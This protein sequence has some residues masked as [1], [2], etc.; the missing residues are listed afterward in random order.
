M[1]STPEVIYP[2]SDSILSNGIAVNLQQT[3]KA[4][5]A[6]LFLP[7]ITITNQAVATIEVLDNPCILALGTSS[8]DVEIAAST[9]L[10]MPNCSIAAAP[11]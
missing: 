9:H 1:G 3:Q 6:V 2:Y 7:D 8:T 4:L 11:G 5:L 10:D